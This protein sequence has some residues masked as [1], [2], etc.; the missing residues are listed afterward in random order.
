[1]R[2]D[3]A[4]SRKLCIR[5]PSPI[6]GPAFSGK[7]LQKEVARVKPL[8]AFRVQKLARS[9]GPRSGLNLGH[10]IFV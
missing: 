7:F 8:H 9:V 6:W 1:M 10:G 5:L 3:G 2:F 4:G